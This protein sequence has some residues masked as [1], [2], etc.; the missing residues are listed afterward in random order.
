MVKLKSMEAKE[1]FY[2]DIFLLEKLFP[3][4]D[5]RKLIIDNLMLNKT[6]H[7][8][9]FGYDDLKEFGL[10]VNKNMPENINIIFENCDL[11]RSKLFYVSR[12]YID[13]YCSNLRFYCRS[14]CFAHIS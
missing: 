7:S 12:I 1:Y 3:D 10:P 5:K 2:D 13:G 9:K 14:Y 4:E 8:I 11:D 6:S